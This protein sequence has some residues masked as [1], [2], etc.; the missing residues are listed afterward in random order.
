M[1]IR[2]SFHLYGSELTSGN[3]YKRPSITTKDVLIALITKEVPRD[4]GA[5]S[6]EPWI[7]SKYIY[8]KYTLVILIIKYI[9]FRNHITERHILIAYPKFT[10]LFF[11]CLPEKGSCSLYRPA[12]LRNCG[13][14]MA[15][16][17]Q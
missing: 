4:L 10:F 3:E 9:F 17:S 1:K 5:L 12:F 2:Y 15:C 11:R 8:E 7:K 16:K 6:Q 14:F 13:F